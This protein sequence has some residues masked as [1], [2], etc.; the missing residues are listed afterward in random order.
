MNQSLAGLPSEL[1][2]RE[3][4]SVHVCGELNDALFKDFM[5]L[6]VPVLSLAFSAS[7]VSRNLKVVSKSVLS[8][9]QKK[10]GVGCVS[11]QAV[12]REQVEGPDVV[13]KRL[14]TVVQRVGKDKIA[15]LHPDCGLRSTGE[16]AVEP[17]LERVSSSARFLRQ[18]E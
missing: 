11:V 6:D 16:E 10:L 2:D 12:R 13:L 15:C 18:A 1:H 5:R 4:L 9:G 14:E 8:S 7:N 3:K 17:I